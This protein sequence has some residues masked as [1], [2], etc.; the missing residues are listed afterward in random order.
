ML[1]YRMIIKGELAIRFVPREITAVYTDDEASG[2][3]SNKMR[4]S[5]IV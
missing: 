5:E 2:G 1:N 4:P 3:T